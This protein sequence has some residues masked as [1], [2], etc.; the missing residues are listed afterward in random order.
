M[1]ISKKSL[2]NQAW[3]F[4]FFGVFFFE[5]GQFTWH[6]TMEDN[7]CSIG[8]MR[9]AH[10]LLLALSLGPWAWLVGRE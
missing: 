2:L 3:V 9:H 10:R 6:F 8:Y 7:V 1:F 4:L 5:E